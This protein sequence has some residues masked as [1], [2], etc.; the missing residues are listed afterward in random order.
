MK[1]IAVTSIQ[2][3]GTIYLDLREMRGLRPGNILIFHHQ[4]IVLLSEVAQFRCQILKG[5]QIIHLSA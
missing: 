2:K 3:Y 4:D 5:G 1:T